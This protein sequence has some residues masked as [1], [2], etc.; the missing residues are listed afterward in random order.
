[1]TGVASVVSD[2]DELDRLKQLPLR[3]WAPG[4]RDHYVRIAK[5]TVTGRRIGDPVLHTRHFSHPLQS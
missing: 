5:H 3:P 1:M 4:D 2:R